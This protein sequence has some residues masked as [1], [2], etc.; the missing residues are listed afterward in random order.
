MHRDKALHSF[1]IEKTW[2][3]TEEWYASIDKSKATGVYASTNPNTIATLKKQNHEFHLHFCEVFVKEESEFLSDFEPWVVMIA[4]DDEHLNTPVTVIMNEF[5]NVQR[6]YLG[7]VK[8]FANLHKGEYTQ[9]TINLWTDIIINT[10]NK[11]VTWFVEENQ[12]YSEEKLFAQQEMINELSS[13][14]I[15]LN[16]HMGLLPLIGVI[17]TAR[18]KLI[19]ENT[20][21]QC[22]EKDISHLLIDLS[23]V[24]IID[25][26]VA[27]QIFSLIETLGLIGVK[28][29][30]SGIRPEIALTAIQLG[31]SFDQVTIKSN[32]A[33]ALASKDFS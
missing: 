6:Q 1:L 15:A 5:F 19:V 13:P 2:Q 23:G 24:L 26:M 25:T 16:N 9:D 10:F 27:Q 11:I 7:F 8:E 18:A 31:L 29:T 28:S 14:V 22:T 33:Q 21:E 3:M 20:L 12:K 30:L 4:K 32:L 17:D